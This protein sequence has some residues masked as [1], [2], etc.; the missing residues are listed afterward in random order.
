V[1]LFSEA[2]LG[3]TPEILWLQKPL[4]LLLLVGSKL[5][6]LNLVWMLLRWN[7]IVYNLLLLERYPIFFVN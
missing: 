1:S 3:C 4:K 6:L 2:T 7:F 5:N